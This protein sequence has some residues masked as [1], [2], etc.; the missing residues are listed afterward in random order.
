M[1]PLLPIVLALITLSCNSQKRIEK[2]GIKSIDFGYGG[3]V[4]G[5]I[6]QYN[7]HPNGDLELGDSA[8]NSIKNKQTYELF[9]Q[10]G[11]L[12]DYR[13]NQPGNMYSF[14]RINSETSNYISWSRG[15]SQIDQSV[16]DLFN[17]LNTLK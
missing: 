4:T 12:M 16:I 17:K 3:G 15:D 10:A 11:R 7:L 13:F 9:R 6:H 2:T 8:I 1:K 14:I 5:A